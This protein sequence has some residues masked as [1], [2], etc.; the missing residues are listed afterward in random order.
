MQLSDAIV[1]CLCTSCVWAAPSS[2]TAVCMI[3]RRLLFAS[4]GEHA[5]FLS[6]SQVSTPAHATA[7]AAMWLVLCRRDVWHG[8]DMAGAGQRRARWNEALLESAVAP[9]YAAL[10]QE[11]SRLL[12][13]CADFWR[14]LPLG[15]GSV[16]E[17]WLRVAAAVYARL[18]DR[19]VLYSPVDG[20]KWLAPQTALLPDAACYSSSSRSGRNAGSQLHSSSISQLDAGASGAQQPADGDSGVDGAVSVLRF[21]PAPLQ[22]SELAGLLV[23]CGVPLVM[24]L[25][26]EQQRCMLQWAPNTAKVGTTVCQTAGLDGWWL[27]IYISYACGV[28]C[29]TSHRQPMACSHGLLVCACVWLSCGCACCLTGV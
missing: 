22:A 2:G 16:P 1:V 5:L 18:A 19:P 6:D 28:H 11:A 17:P 15:Q 4:T 27:H 12:G 14:L 26:E 29:V 25:S 9:A 8:D 24:G 13:P 10:L 21:V 7:G 20:G 23:Q 3:H